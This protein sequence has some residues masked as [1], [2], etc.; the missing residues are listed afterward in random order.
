MTERVDAFRWREHRLVYEVH[1]DGEHPFVYT[2]GLMLDATLNR[3]IARMLARRGHCVILPELLGHGRSD[4]PAHAY[5][6]R[7]EFWAQQT[8]ALL[9]HLGIDRA[10]VGGVSLGANVALHV[11]ESAPERVH[12]LVVEMPVLERGTLVGAAA[13]LPLLL[14][15]RYAPSLFRPVAG[16]ARRVPPTGHPLD[17]FV[18]LAGA[19]PRQHAAVLHGLFVGP[20]TV[21]EVVRRQLPHRTLV[22]GHG[23]DMLHALDDAQALAREMPNAT[24]VRARSVMEARTRPERVVQA[25]DEFLTDVWG[26]ADESAGRTIAGAARG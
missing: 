6:Y 21:P 22:L 19:E 2:H 23:R 20:T 4:K 1:G 24:F 18:H 11:A 13:F 7:M 12:A 8:V 5:Q 9:D 16:L 26:S 14:G 10:V 3:T 17:S 15:L 25:M